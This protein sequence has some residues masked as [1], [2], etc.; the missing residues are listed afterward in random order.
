MRGRNAL[1]WRGLVARSGESEHAAA[2][3]G[4]A[5]KAPPRWRGELVGA[6]SVDPPA[7][8]VVWWPCSWYAN[9][10]QGKTSC[11][12]GF[13]YWAP[14]HPGPAPERVRRR[15]WSSRFCCWSAWIQSQPSVVTRLI[16]SSLVRIRLASST[17]ALLK[18][19]MTQVL[20]RP[21]IL[22]AEGNGTI[23]GPPGFKSLKD[24]LA[25][26]IQ[27]YVFVELSSFRV[28]EVPRLSKATSNWPS[29]IFA[30]LY[31]PHKNWTALIFTITV[32]NWEA[33]KCSQMNKII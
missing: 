27:L 22:Q 14:A 1:R 18:P 28:V 30:T 12:T 25:L 33:F 31:R 2:D 3:V 32:S 24:F 4:A 23:R 21:R 13:G 8:L 17:I 11:T 20:E 26:L 6:T 15:S 5:G 9:V 10:S 29:A 19:R 16:T 7:E